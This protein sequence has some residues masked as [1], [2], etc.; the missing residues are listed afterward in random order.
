[1]GLLILFHD[2]SA[3]VFMC[4]LSVV[5]AMIVE[6]TDMAIK[7]SMSIFLQTLSHWIQIGEQK[8]KWIVIGLIQRERKT[9]KEAC[10]TLFHPTKQASERHINT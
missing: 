3:L 6:S 1:M 2:A 7:G 4:D 8:C 10:F 9:A 5:C